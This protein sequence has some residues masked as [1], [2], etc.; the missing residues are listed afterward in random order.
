MPEE[1][2][3]L[4]KPQISCFS[5]NTKIFRMFINDKEIFNIFL[6]LSCRSLVLDLP[7]SFSLENFFVQQQ[8]QQQTFA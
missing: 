7:H 6:E 4:V 1:D 2:Q 5:C 3:V 8:Q